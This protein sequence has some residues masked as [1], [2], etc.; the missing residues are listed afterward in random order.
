M[1]RERISLKAKGTDPYSCANVHI[2]SSISR[3]PAT[4]GAGRHTRKDLAQLCRAVYKRQVRIVAEGYLASPSK[5]CKG[6]RLGQRA[7]RLPDVVSISCQH[8]LAISLTM[9]VLGK[10][11]QLSRTP[12]RSS[13]SFHWSF[14]A[15][16]SIVGHVGVIL[17][18]QTSQDFRRDLFFYCITTAVE[19]LF[20]FSLVRICVQSQASATAV[21]MV[22]FSRIKSWPVGCQADPQ[23]TTSMILREVDFA[24]FFLFSST[25][26]T[27]TKMHYLCIKLRFPNDEF[28]SVSSAER[29]I[30]MAGRLDLKGHS[31]SE[32]DLGISRGYK[33][34]F[35]RTGK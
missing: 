2:A 24:S 7:S 12:S 32:E 23:T 14:S 10:T 9:R 29:A 3:R 5:G 34:L 1:W 30:P 13:T 6:L 27:P 18:G 21:D 19:C 4:S 26:I 11:F 31:D 8:A 33:H 16:K 25:Y 17:V 35:F 22:S 20:R 28:T 15:S